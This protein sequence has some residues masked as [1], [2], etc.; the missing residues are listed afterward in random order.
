MS[1]TKLKRW[2]IR[3]VTLIQGISIRHKAM[4]TVGVGFFMLTVILV[5]Y[6][7]TAARDS[8]MQRLKDNVR[9]TVLNAY[10]EIEHVY[11]RVDRKEITSEQAL[12]ELRY[13]L[14]GPLSEIILH[15][16]GS[17]EDL[18]GQFRKMVRVLDSKALEGMTLQRGPHDENSSDSFFT[19]SGKNRRLIALIEEAG[20]NIGFRVTD[21]E[22]VGH[23]YRGYYA[24]PEE[25]RTR[26]REEARIAIIRDLS[27][28]SIKIGKDGYVYILRRYTPGWLIPGTRYPEDYTEDTVRHRYRT[29]FAGTSL[30][31]KEREQYI[32]RYGRTPEENLAL[33]HRDMTEL[34][35]PPRGIIAI[36]HPY[37]E[38]QD[39]D[40]SGYAGERPARN[41]VLRGQGHYRYAWKNPGE[42]D[43][44]YKVVFLKTFEHPSL[45]SPWVVGCGGY[46][47]D[48]LHQVE[49]LRFHIYII[50]GSVSLILAA[51]VMVF[52]RM[53]IMDPLEALHDTIKEVNSG[54]LDTPIR[55]SYKDEIGYIAK[56]LNMMLRN[57]RRSNKK[58]HEYATTLEHKVSERTAELQETLA[59]V[60]DLKVKQDGDYYLTSLLLKPLGANR[61]ASETVAVDFLVKQKKQFVFRK[62]D[63]EIGGDL[64][65][66][67]SIRLK[68][69]DYTVFLNADAMG[70]SLQGAG[71]A[72]VIG[73]VFGSI[74]ERTVS[75]FVF[76]DYYP[77]RWLKNTFMELR[78]IFESF[79]GAM[80][81]SIVIGLVE[82]HT[83]MVYYINAEHPF[84]VLYRKGKA[85]FI[86]TETR[87]K[88]LGVEDPDDIL[89]IQTMH[90]RPGDMLFFGSDGK[91]DI[92][93][94]DDSASIN[95]D[96]T[97]F[98][99]IVE[100]CQ[101]DLDAI[102]NDLIGRG[103]LTDDLSLLRI[104]YSPPVDQSSRPRILSLLDLARKAQS[105]GDTSTMVE[106][107]R[108]IL[109]IEPSHRKALAEL[110]NYHLKREEYDQVLEY[111]EAYI[112]ANP[113]NLEI[114]YLLAYAYRKQKQYSRAIDL[115]ERVYLREPDQLK[116]LLNLAFCY[117]RIGDISRAEYFIEKVFALDPENPSAQRLVEMLA[118]PHNNP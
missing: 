72:L 89:S 84:G 92:R 46:E 33:V 106:H 22:L 58:L 52:I 110:I 14:A 28:S 118:R 109:Q 59:T 116:N 3:V 86:E 73:S 6:M 18:E 112:E 83:G 82:D 107:Y 117:S 71:G 34:H 77:E 35:D 100:K 74:L 102:Y 67:R 51:T 114:L 79:N 29:H 37:L 50:G 91:D 36:V 63:G 87:L 42:D 24:L 81:A 55:R 64:C 20:E 32:E 115:G 30:R 45:S 108:E 17:S 40:N 76:K 93:L 66:A 78:K 65:I 39:L 56:S 53:N 99:R 44:R 69:R 31:G 19:G 9:M 49:E 98:L 25:K 96:E 8:A 26:F 70:K 12:H 75:S 47:E 94:G 105:E 48:V 13:R 97:L 54:K 103:E 95:E 88:R 41:L 5:E 90:L 61:A 62:W 11:E 111:G 27:Q 68:E 15:T 101:G 60:Q 4:L 43:V 57:I 80:G 1:L 21:P 113:A 104:T 10:N 2:S 16:H 38:D 85:G 7:Y 23:L